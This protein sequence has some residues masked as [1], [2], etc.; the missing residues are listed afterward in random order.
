V[1][2]LVIVGTGLAGYSLARE[3]RRLAPEPP[4]VLLT[5]DG[6]AF[7]SKPMLS[8]ALAGGKGVEDIPSATAEGM[9]RDLRA[10]V[11]VRVSVT[12]LDPAS[13]RLRVDGAELHYSRLVLALGADPIRLPLAGDAS[14]EV[15]SVN[16]L[17]DYARFRRRLAP[18]A[19]VMVL[20]AGLIGCEFAS[21]L[22]AAGHS[23]TVADPA[24]WPL[25]RLVPREAGEALRDGLSRAGVRWRLG[26]SA[27][28]VEARPAGCL[29]TLASGAEEQADL[30]LSAVGLVPRTDLATRARL[31]VGRGVRADR[32]LRTSHPEVYALGDCAEVDGLVLPYVMPIM[33]AA[34]ALARTLA[35][36][37]TAVVYPA[38]PV[39]VKTPA[40]PTV[41]AP[42]PAGT[43]GEWTTESTPSGLRSLFR[44]ADRRLLGFVLS[45]NRASERAALAREL[46]PLLP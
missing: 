6:G 45:G 20:G 13:H 3:W 12:G 9:A 8:A 41:V 2:P 38:M 11:R 5:R 18:A 37:P 19:R 39:V 43:V 46:P 34:R 31:E 10:E 22:V 17:D 25:A 7:Y 16:D 40:W 14:P 42:P 15:L 27:S 30:V 1:D 4:L 36:E 28:A 21:D 26:D 23:V 44:S 33:Q 35:G 29:V 24:T 32:Y